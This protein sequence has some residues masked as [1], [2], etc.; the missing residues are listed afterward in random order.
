MNKIF[1]LLSDYLSWWFYIRFIEI[2][3]NSFKKKKIQ[4]TI[5]NLLVYFF[6]PLL[7]KYKCESFF[8]EFK[9]FPKIVYIN[10]IKNIN[11]FKFS[12]IEIKIVKLKLLIIASYF[13][14]FNL[15][16]YFIIDNYHKICV[17]YFR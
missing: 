13:S 12:G 6:N 1:S 8:F 4:L 5:L 10:I 9:N 7:H 17:F 3:F 15:E 14:I 2:Q 16:I 11:C